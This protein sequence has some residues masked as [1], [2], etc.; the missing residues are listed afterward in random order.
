MQKYGMGDA[1]TI[2]EIIS[3]VDSDNVSYFSNLYSLKYIYSS[4]KHAN[5]AIHRMEKLTMRSSVQ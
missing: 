2:K 4:T 5:T 1:A 3:E